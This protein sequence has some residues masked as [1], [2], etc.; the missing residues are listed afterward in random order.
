M[1][2][3]VNTDD[4]YF[5]FKRLTYLMPHE[6]ALVMYGFDYDVSEKDLSSEQL[7]DVHKL[8]SAITRNIQLFDEYKNASAKKRIEANLVLTAAYIFQREGVVPLE[9]KER[10][11]IAVQQVVKDKDWANVLIT[12][13]GN[14]LYEVGKRL[15]N[16][17]RG[18]YRKEDEDNNNW[19]L[20][21]LLIEL[22][23]KYGKA[24][25]A[26]LSVIYNDILSLCQE[27][28]I[29]LEGIKQATFYK[30]VKIARDIIKY[31]K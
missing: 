1:M 3:N 15:R 7:K 8:R 10:I 4:K 14:E 27:R 11:N 18:Q 19:K 23:S 6:V 16:N 17:G 21:A 29:S 28:N 12:L 22:L 13:G 5:Y 31:G 24:S 26:D 9:V 20:I 30:K 25:Y 2:D